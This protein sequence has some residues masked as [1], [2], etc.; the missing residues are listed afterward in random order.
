M[1]RL[2][3]HTEKPAEARSLNTKDDTALKAALLIY[4]ATTVYRRTLVARK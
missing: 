3:T 1:N 2:S 4:H